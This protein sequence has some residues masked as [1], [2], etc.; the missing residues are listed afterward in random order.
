MPSVAQC[1][2]FAVQCRE[3]AKAHWSGVKIYNGLSIACVR[4]SA[5]SFSIMVWAAIALL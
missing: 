5:L 3:G 1:L 4:A 2:A